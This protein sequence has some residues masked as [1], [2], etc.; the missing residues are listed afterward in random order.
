MA[1][2][3]ILSSV[4]D[5][6]YPYFHNNSYSNYGTIGLIQNPTARFNKAG[7]I[8]FS[9][10]H[11]DPYING[12]ILAYPFDWLEASYQYTDINNALYSRVKRFSGNQSYKD[13]GFD[14]LNLCFLKR[15]YIFRK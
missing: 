6:I 3:P 13:K 1:S 11:R 5:Y 2:L 7:T 12:S 10:S 14:F 8:G 4:N 9:W 15:V